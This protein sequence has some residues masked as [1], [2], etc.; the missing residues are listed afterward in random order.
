MKS[1]ITIV[2]AENP[3]TSLVFQVCQSC[4]RL[5]NRVNANV[6]VNGMSL[7]V[8]FFSID[9][10]DDIIISCISLYPNNRTDMGGGKSKVAAVSNKYITDYEMKDE[11]KDE[12]ENDD[13]TVWEKGLLDFGSRTLSEDEFEQSMS[14][15]E[16]LVGRRPRPRPRS[17]TW[18]H[19]IAEE[20]GRVVKRSFMCCTG[21]SVAFKVSVNFKPHISDLADLM[22]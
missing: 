11:M 10:I 12:E 17:S 13:Q 18:S 9:I 3:E 16:T 22:G 20:T 15:S 7:C 21:N 1:L 14:D 5:T 4:G 6:I 19:P 8:S 2:Y